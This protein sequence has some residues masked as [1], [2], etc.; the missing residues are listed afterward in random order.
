M[1]QV[2]AMCM[3]RDEYLSKGQGLSRELITA[4]LYTE[5]YVMKDDMRFFCIN[6]I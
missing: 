4:F 1:G 6:Q 5:L 2:S 3:Q